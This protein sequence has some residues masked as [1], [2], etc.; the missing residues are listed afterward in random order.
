[1]KGNKTKQ[2]LMWVFVKLIDPA[3]IG[4]AAYSGFDFVIIDLEDGPHSIQSTQNL[5]RAAELTGITP[6]IR[7]DFGKN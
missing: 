2:N 3:V 1:M 5:I 4:I 7:Q 6:V